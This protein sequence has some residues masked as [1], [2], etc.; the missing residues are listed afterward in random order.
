MSDSC[1]L[2][3]RDN[4]TFTDQNSFNSSPEG[5]AGE[6]N[7]NRNGHTYLVVRR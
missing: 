3:E 4:R 5:E 6:E 1:F 2:L 7:R